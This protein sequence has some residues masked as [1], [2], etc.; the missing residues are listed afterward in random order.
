MLPFVRRLRDVIR[1]HKA[2]RL[3][4][5][6]K[7]PSRLRVGEVEGLCVLLRRLAYPGRYGD[8]AVMFGRSP[9]ALCLIFRFM[10]DLIYAKCSKLLARGSPIDRCIGFIDS[11]VGSFEASEAR[12]CRT[13]G[14]PDKGTKTWSAK[15]D[16][17]D[18][19]EERV[20]I[21]VPGAE[22]LKGLITSGTTKL[23]KFASRVKNRLAFNNQ[24]GTEDSV[25]KLGVGAM[26]SKRTDTALAQSVITINN[27]RPELNEEAFHSALTAKYDV[28]ALTKI[29][30]DAQRPGASKVATMVEAIQFDNWVTQKKTAGD[31]YNLLKLNVEDVDVLVNPLL[32]TWISFVKTKLKEDPYDFLLLKLAKQYEEDALH[33]RLIAAS[34]TASTRDIASGLEFAQIKKWLTTGKA[35]DDV[36][37]ISLVPADKELGL[38]KHP[39][40]QTFISYA[41]KHHTLDPYEFLVLKLAKRH[42]E[43]ELPKMLVRAKSDSDLVSMAVKLESTQFKIWK[44]KGKT[45]DDVFKMLRLDIDQ[46]IDTLKSP[47]LVSWFS[48]VK[49][50]SENPTEVL[51]RK[52]EIRF[53]DAE[54]LKMFFAGRKDG[55]LKFSL[56]P[57]VRLI[58]GNWLGQKKTAEDVFTDLSL[59]KDGINFFENPILVTWFTYVKSMHK[60]EADN[61]MSSVMTKYYD[62]ETL[63]KMVTH[64][65]ITGNLKATAAQ[66][67]SALWLREGMPAHEAFKLLR[68]S[69]KG[70]NALSDPAFGT[71]VSYFNKLQGKKMNQDDSSNGFGKSIGIRKNLATPT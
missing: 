36:L 21:K 43:D 31:I 65:S 45:S 34:T 41:T 26:E 57:M 12:P 15:D 71:W 50:I 64:S 30:V 11:T 38:L 53:S 54:I 37:K 33:K 35:E 48:Y 59:H 24:K 32:P 23:K 20:D 28:E 52:L 6:Y 51:Y 60:E 68:L 56:G 14:C 55:T 29:L 4:E 70:D 19:S 44:E 67:A 25:A 2:L 61:V 63:K 39:A 5:D 40:L 17:Y 7:L 66:V 42:G 16:E 62:D 3:E 8:L 27:K 1:L 22:K 9:S 69:G 58:K 47:G 18:T 46:S 49:K 13:F 10:V